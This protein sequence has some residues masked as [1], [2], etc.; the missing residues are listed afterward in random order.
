MDESKHALLSPGEEDSRKDTRAGDAHGDRPTPSPSLRPD[1]ESS[2]VEIEEEP[3]Q[4]GAA[5][6]YV[7]QAGRYVRS[8][9]SWM[10]NHTGKAVAAVLFVASVLAFVVLLF[11]GV[12]NKP[13]LP[14][15]VAVQ[16]MGK[17]VCA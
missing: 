16:K 17:W 6:G 2:A 5:E 13:L 15:L 9:V 11:M 10:R 14:V 1:E 4:V 7:R 3:E 8:V 12:F